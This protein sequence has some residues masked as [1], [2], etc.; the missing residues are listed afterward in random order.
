MDLWL[1]RK[2]PPPKKYLETRSKMQGLIDDYSRRA[3]EAAVED[4]A[5]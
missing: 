5:E 4:V 2:D 3:K 1:E